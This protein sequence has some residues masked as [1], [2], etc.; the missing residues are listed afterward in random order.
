MTQTLLSD[1]PPQRPALVWPIAMLAFAYAVVL[2]ACGVL[3][4]LGRMSMSVGAQLLGNGMEVMGPA[5]YFL[6]SIALGAGALGLLRAQK[7]SRLLLVIVC[8][9]G[10]LLIVPHISSAVVDE[11]YA[12]MSLDGLQILVRVAIASYLWREREWFR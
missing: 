6:Y 2:S 9:V 8:A 10:I 5:P 12:A 1:D 4:I 3:S 11:R 7:W